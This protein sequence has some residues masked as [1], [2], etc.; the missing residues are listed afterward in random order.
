MFRPRLPVVLTLMAGG[1]VLAAPAAAQP[2]FKTYQTK[3]YVL[4]TDLE[5][6]GVKEI[7]RRLTVMAEEFHYRTR[8]F[9]GAVQNRLP[10]HVFSRPED[11]YAV[12]G[13]PGSAGVFMGDRLMVVAGEEL[14][15]RSW[16]VIQHEAFHQFAAAAIGRGLPPW[17]NEGLA[18]YFGH[19]VFT[20]DNFYTGLIPSNR[21]AQI[22]QGIKEDKFKSLSQ[23]M[24]LQQEVW[25]AEINL[26]HAQAGH[27][28]L[29]AWSMIHFLAHANDGRYQDAF[30]DFLRAVGRGQPWEQ[31]WVRA[32]GNR[33]DAFQQRWE[34]YWLSLPADPTDDLSAE[35]TVSIIT[36]FFARA[37]SQ[38]QY[39]DT[40]D[41]FLAAAEAG[42]LKAHQEDWLPPR[43]LQTAIK[44]MPEAGT[45]SLQ[46]RPGK[47]LV[48]CQREDGTIMEGH[49]RIK[50]RRVQSVEVRVRPPKKKRE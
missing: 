23:M 31:A 21:V 17:A 33:V 8:G 37:F 3:Y 45:W 20:G 35:I 28:Y 48:V 49:F 11:Y 15:T 4:H 44:K 12:G 2:G 22:Q 16:H 26:A 6:D 38:R 30:A 34:E 46:R 14:S 41:E 29:Q 42:R 27:N 39:F 32:F 19:G 40:L 7:V 13:M 50:N 1:L 24:R 36:S 25:N 5:A 43:L 18:E 47:R 10:I 9:A